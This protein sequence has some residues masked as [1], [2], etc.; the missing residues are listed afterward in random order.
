MNSLADLPFRVSSA[1]VRTYLPHAPGV[2][3]T[4]VK[5]NSLKL[6]INYDLDGG[7]Y[8]S[9][10]SSCGDEATD[11][12]TWSADVSSYEPLVRGEWIHF[13]GWITQADSGATIL[14]L[15]VN[16][17]YSEE[18]QG[19]NDKPCIPS[20]NSDHDVFIQGISVAEEI[21]MTPIVVVPRFL[22]PKELQKA[23]YE[24]K[25]QMNQLAGP[26]RPDSARLG[27]TFEY[28]RSLFN[29]P[30]VLLA[31]PLL[32]QKRIGTTKTC[33]NDFCTKLIERLWNQVSI[34]GLCKHPYVCLETKS[35]ELLA[36]KDAMHAPPSFFGRPPN[37]HDQFVELLMSLTSAGLIVRDS[38]PLPTTSFLDTGTKDV[39]LVLILFAPDS[40]VATKV[41]V[42]AVF[43]TGSIDVYD[44]ALPV[45]RERQAHELC[46]RSGRVVLALGVERYGCAQQLV[47]RP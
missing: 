26:S 25:P 17:I 30:A 32:A 10:I 45:H 3:M 28:E 11:P 20:F 12:V 8:F 44:A 24:K 7:P 4:V 39:Q 34:A 33:P 38:T 42:D 23:Y 9:F 27:A 29:S 36:C 6:Q 5:T 41:I 37:D 31:P 15:M 40:G 2:R 22:T 18:K 47:E 1:A 16:A 13:S 19:P 43:D 35:T 46:G 21:L 14:G